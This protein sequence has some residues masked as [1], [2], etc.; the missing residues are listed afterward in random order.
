MTH[1]ADE[2]IVNVLSLFDQIRAE[3]RNRAAQIVEKYEIYSPYVV[4][5][6]SIK[7]IKSELAKLIRE[8]E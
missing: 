4:R 2:L 5:K 3:E 1:T 7:R 6:E 8:G